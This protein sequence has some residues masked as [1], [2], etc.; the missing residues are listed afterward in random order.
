MFIWKGWALRALLQYFLICWAGVT[1]GQTIDLPPRPAQALGGQVIADK[2]TSMSFVERENFLLH[3]VLSGNVPDFYRKFCPVTVTNVS[4]GQT[5]A[6]TFYAAPECLMVGAEDD[7]LLTPVSP[8]TAQFIADQLHCVLPTPRMSDAI[9]AAA[10]VKL[11]PA[12]IPPTPAMTTAAV[13]IRHNELVRQQRAAFLAAH[14][15]GALTAGDKKDVVICARLASLPHKV[16]IY[17]WHQTNGVAI[18]PLYTGHTSAWVDYS[19]GIRLVLSALTVNGGSNSIPA[20]LADPRLCGLLSNEGV[21]TNDA[22]PTN[23]IV[24]VTPVALVKLDLP[25][26]QQF[27]ATTNFGERVRQID[28]GGDGRVLVD[29][30][31]ADAFSPDKPVLL[32]FYALPNGNS[33][34]QTFGKQL[35]PGDDWHFDIQH[36]GAQTRWL[37][38]AVTNRTVVVAYLEAPA[39]SWPAWRREPGHDDAATVRIVQG[40]SGI[41]SAYK[42]ELALTSHSGGGSFVCG[43]LGAVKA[44]PD[45][46]V[47]IAFLDSDYN[48]TREAHAQKLVNWLAASPE[49]HLVVLAYHDALAL[50]NGKPF[51][52]EAGGTWGRSHALLA[53]LGEHFTFTSQTNGPLETY[54]AGNGRI[55]FLL[56]ENPE[57]QILHTVQ[58]ERNG[59]IQAMVSGTAREGAGYAYFGERA[60]TN[61]IQAGVLNAEGRR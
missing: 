40:V 27:T 42:L 54:S 32:I 44:I 49:H 29:A 51:V 12:P 13:F 45:N 56:H 26:P 57:K 23:A 5:N 19:H 18:Q 55:Q 1:L 38:A 30:P 16:A 58:V 52:S 14:P 33:I 60:Y 43:W 28:L 41:F 22:Y 25:W 53:D 6:A 61:W 2:I 3:E 35:A 15:L 11:A 39:K 37:R 17:G 8:A 46:V 4:G 47:R 7:Y 59:F 50:L 34:E 24:P 20:V 36:I 21:I 48:Y 31:V 10:A 9:Y